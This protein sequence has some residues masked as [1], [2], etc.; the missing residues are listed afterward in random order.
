M[1]RV[2]A[3]R[4][5]LAV[6]LIVSYRSP[7]G[8]CGLCEMGSGMKINRVAEL[9]VGVACGAVPLSVNSWGR[10][11]RGV[12]WEREKPLPTLK[13]Y[14]AG[15]ESQAQSSDFFSC[16]AAQA[17]GRRKVIGRCHDGLERPL[18]RCVIFVSPGEPIKGVIIGRWLRGLLYQ[19]GAKSQA[20]SC[21]IKLPQVTQTPQA[22]FRRK[23]IG[24]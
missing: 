1:F 5:A 23:V 20:P 19:T 10:V 11:L 3:S 8:S 13:G 17:D 16:Q 4:C 2:A 21:K 14:N 18:D 7:V 12:E 15:S 9:A 24:R 22:A 6:Y